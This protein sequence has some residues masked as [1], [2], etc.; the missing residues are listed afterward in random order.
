MPL[1]GLLVGNTQAALSLVLGIYRRCPS[2]LPQFHTSR[3]FY[4]EN[5]FHILACNRR[6]HELCECVQLAAAHLPRAQLES[7]FQG[8][9]IGLFFG[10]C[11]HARTR[12]LVMLLESHEHIRPHGWFIT[13]RVC[14]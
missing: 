1:H 3:L 12:G 10:N 7:I 14:L 4:G 5:S 11:M 9:A 2:L 13:A 8:Q 6:E